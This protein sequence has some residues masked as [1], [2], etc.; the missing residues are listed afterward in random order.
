[1]IVLRPLVAAFVDAWQVPLVVT[2]G[3]CHGL[4]CRLGSQG[5]LS[6]I[7]TLLI[8]IQGEFV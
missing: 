7:P 1:M 3:A 2:G 6:G 8:D 4:L 5:K